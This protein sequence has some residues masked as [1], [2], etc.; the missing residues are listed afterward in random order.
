MLTV[1]SPLQSFKTSTVSE[2]NVSPKPQLDMINA[3]IYKMYIDHALDCQFVQLVCIAT[4]NLCMCIAANTYYTLDLFIHTHT[5]THRQKES[6]L[7]FPAEHPY[8]SH[9]SRFAVFPD[10]KSNLPCIQQAVQQSAS[11]GLRP[12]TVSVC[13]QT[14]LNHGSQHTATSLSTMAPKPATPYYVF[15]KVGERGHRVESR[16]LTQPVPVET[17]SGSQGCGLLWDMPRSR[18]HQVS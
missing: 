6:H 15:Q 1:F 10:T 9:I 16:S 7:P 12:D 3:V 4:M 8:T 2:S 18:R 13:T 17:R 14:P 5:L 11:P